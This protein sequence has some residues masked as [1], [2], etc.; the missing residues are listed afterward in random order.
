MGLNIIPEVADCG[1]VLQGVSNAYICTA[2]QQ[3]ENRWVLCR[4]TEYNDEV[5][6]NMRGHS[7]HDLT[8]H[9]GSGL[10]CHLAAEHTEV[11]HVALRL[12]PRV[13]GN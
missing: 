6:G 1:R 10:G 9:S 2:D 7:E 3:G 8:W 11:L 5:T 13:Y 4:V 12:I